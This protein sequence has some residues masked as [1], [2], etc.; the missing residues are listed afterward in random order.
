MATSRATGVMAKPKHRCPRTIA[1][2]GQSL[3]ELTFMVIVLVWLLA[4]ILDLGR[5]YFT[6]IALRDAAGEGAY[7]G[8]VHPTWQ[9]SSDNADPNNITYRVKNSAPT[10]GLVDWSSAT[11][12]ITAPSPT[13]GNLLT[14]TVSYNYTLLTPFVG[15]IVGSQTLPL[16]ATAT[17]EILSAGP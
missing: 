2:R 13:P 9:T 8:S 14:V 4:G 1:Q 11:V 15:T 10:G 6:F 16:S 3:V 12:T 7:Y 17:A 5:A